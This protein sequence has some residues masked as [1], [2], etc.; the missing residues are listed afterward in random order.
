M[1]HSTDPSDRGQVPRTRQA[2]I[3]PAT[4]GLP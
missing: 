3:P 4:R 2:T 1:R